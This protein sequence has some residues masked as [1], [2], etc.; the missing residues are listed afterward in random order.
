MIHIL[1]RSWDLGND[2]KTF[3]IKETSDRGLGVFASRDFRKADHIFRIDLRRLRT[4][5]VNEIDE[6]PGLE[7]EHADYVGHGRYVIDY[8]PVSYMNHSCNP[9]CFVKMRTIAVKDVHALRDIEEGEELTYDYTA[10]SVDQFDGK[11]S[12]EEECRC[13]S[14]NC[15]GILQGDLFKLPRKLQR[16]YYPNLPPS[17]KRKH[18]DLFTRLRSEE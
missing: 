1:N 17:I 16:A 9:N 10:T 15:R 13:A 3:I 5:S 7:G 2:V 18:R 14:K 4:Y 8:S 11:G 12:W 6:N